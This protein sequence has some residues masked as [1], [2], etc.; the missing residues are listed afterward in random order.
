MPLRIDNTLP[1]GA[2]VTPVPTLAGRSRY[3]ATAADNLSG[4]ASVRFD[5]VTANQAGW[6]AICT[7]TVAPFTCD[8]AVPAADQQ[9]D[10][11]VVITDKAGNV[12]TSA[13]VDDRPGGTR[14]AGA[15]VQ[16]A[17]GGVAGTLDAGDTFT[18]TYSEAI[19]P[20]SIASGWNGVA[21]AR[22]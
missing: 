7:D 8:W 21:H 1:T 22:P 18:F 20:G 5:R 19:A 11:R 6:T 15:D 12:R 9:W 2:V 3:G 10:L 14:P 13:V 4:V 17:N 16:G